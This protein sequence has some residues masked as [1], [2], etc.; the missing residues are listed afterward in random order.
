MILTRKVSASL[1][2]GLRALAS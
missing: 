1:T 2:E